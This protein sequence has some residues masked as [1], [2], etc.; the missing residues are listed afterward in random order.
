M[1]PMTMTLD[2]AQLWL[3]LAGRAG[4]DKTARFQLFDMATD[5]NLWPLCNYA[6]RF[7]TSRRRSAWMAEN[8]ASDVLFQCP[9]VWA[10]ASATDAPKYLELRA[11]TSRLLAS[12]PQPVSGWT[13]DQP[14]IRLLRLVRKFASDNRLPHLQVRTRGENFVRVS[15]GFVT[16]GNMMDAYQM[17]ENDLRT[18][19]GAAFG[20]TLAYR[21][22][23]VI[24]HG[25]MRW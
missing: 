6:R 4:W 13:D 10:L 2:Q 21:Q 8:L 24:G 22:I 18:V 14:R 23:R 11:A 20:E 1:Q 15:F 9:A 19:I 25:P 16:S 12:P 7:E 3:L 5:L 17:L